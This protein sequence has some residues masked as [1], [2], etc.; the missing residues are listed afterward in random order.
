LLYESCLLDLVVSVAIWFASWLAWP[1]DSLLALLCYV[2]PLPWLY[3]FWCPTVEVLLACLLILVC[4]D[5]FRSWLLLGKACG[6]CQV[7]SVGGV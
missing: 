2:V 1:S 4:W 3:P 5:V 7:T 6:L